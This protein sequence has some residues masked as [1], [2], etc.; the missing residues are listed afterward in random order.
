MKH[1]RYDELKLGDIILF[2]G[3]LVRIVELKSFPAPANEYF[4][5]EKTI[6]FTIE[7][8]ND[9]SIKILGNF[10]SRGIYGGVGCLI[11]TIIE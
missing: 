6:N 3:A 10:Y 4:K 1:V 8:I 11:V 7:P 9:E 2:H 5:N